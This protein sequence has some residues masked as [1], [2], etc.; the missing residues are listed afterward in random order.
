MLSAA[1]LSLLLAAAPSLD[2]LF[3]KVDG[4]VVTVRVG[5]R[6]TV[7]TESSAVLAVSIGTGSGVL[8][9]PAGYV[10]TAAHVVE[11]SNAIECVWR[12]GFKAEA[13]IVSLSRTEDLALL[14]VAALPPKP[15][16]VALGDSEALKPGMRLFAIGAPYGLDHTLT[17]G[18]VSALRSN[19]QRGLMPKKLVQTDLALNQGNSGGPLFNDAGEVVA[20]ASFMLSKS[21]GSVGLNF[22]VPSSTVRTRL[23]EHALPYI[24]VSLRYIPRDVAE[25]FNWPVES[26]F[27]V[28]HVRAGSAAEKAGLKAGPVSADVA[29]NQVMLGGDLIVKVN[30]VDTGST[31]KVAQVLRTLKGGDVIHYDVLRGGKPATVD[32]TVPD[33][34]EIP[35]LPKRR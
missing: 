15:V 29:G 27:L 26:G 30:G 20:I 24:G 18:V 1:T 23:F 14:K 6:H 32:V 19:L 5:T 25:I 33:G 4:S 35:A 12:D 28:E 11:D 3:T 9:H 17:S 13:T 2:E 7:E 22:A 16:V 21:G 31:E 10:V 34:L 8:V